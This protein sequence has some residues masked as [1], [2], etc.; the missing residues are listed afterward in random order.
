VG[1]LF[2]DTGVKVVGACYC[3]VILPQQ[4]YVKYLDISSVQRN[5][6]P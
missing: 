3:D 6:A 1:L 2:V 5:S 4:L